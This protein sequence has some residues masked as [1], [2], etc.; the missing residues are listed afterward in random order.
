MG[1]STAGRVTFWWPATLQHSRLQSLLVQSCKLGYINYQHAHIVI[2]PP[3]VARWLSPGLL[4]LQPVEGP[5]PT[6]WSAQ[7][8]SWELEVQLVYRPDT[9]WIPAAWVYP[10]ESAAGPPP[11]ARV[12]VYSGLP[13]LPRWMLSEA[14][15]ARVEPGS[16]GRRP[17]ALR[18]LACM[19]TVVCLARHPRW[20][21]VDPG[22]AA[23]MVVSLMAWLG[24]AHPAGF[25]LH[26]QLCELLSL[27]GT[28]H[29]RLWLAVTPWAATLLLRLML[30]AVLVTTALGSSSAG[31]R[32]AHAAARCAE[33][34]TTGPARAAA[35]AAARAHLAAAAR[36]WRVLRGL[37]PL[38][39]LR[40]ALLRAAPPADGAQSVRVVVASVLL[41]MPLLLLLPTTLAYAGACAA[42]AA[43]L[44]LAEGALRLAACVAERGLGLEGGSRV[45][46]VAPGRGAAP[47]VL[48]PS[49]RLGGPLP[50]RLLPAWRRWRGDPMAGTLPLPHWRLAAG[51]VCLALLLSLSPDPVP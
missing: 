5:D 39:S 22:P 33:R 46:Q 9:D 20:T 14:G 29:A 41:L 50:R 34:A 1:E 38:P 37:E 51:L 7:V 26:P 23:L 48:S 17:T 45:R 21:R 6:L 47:V 42:L 32:A 3:S 18:V 8:G 10:A 40:C 24:D 2:A 4:P 31:L 16:K 36:M 30:A 49:G 35:A 12:E 25:K 28:A 27:A 43:P 13:A 44:R 11:E 15:L 19:A